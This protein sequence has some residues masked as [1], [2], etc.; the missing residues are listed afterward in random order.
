MLGN[1]SG[2]VLYAGR[3]AAFCVILA[4]ALAALCV[5]L[6]VLGP[7]LAAAD[8]AQTEGPPD[9]A[10]P[11]EAWVK[12]AITDTP[13]PVVAGEELTYA[14]SATN[15]GPAVASNLRMWVE[16]PG[17]SDFVSSSFS[18]GSGEGSCK[19]VDAQSFGTTCLVESLA[20]GESAVFEVVVRPRHPGREHLVFDAWAENGPGLTFETSE[21]TTVL[22]PRGCTIYGTERGDSFGGDIHGT[23][24]PDV[25]CALGGSDRVYGGGGDDTILAGEGDD[26]VYGGEGDDT[27]RGGR[28][29]EFD[30]VGGAGGDDIFGG[31]GSDDLRARDGVRGNDEARG[32]SGY[33]IV[34]A[35][36]GDFARD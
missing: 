19:P 35:D 22:D 26:T 7:G 4:M 17:D 29:N 10:L 36:P 27:I 12:K 28:G 5:P 18:P 30:L 1:G 25:I 8:P 33:D 14:A 3:A 16:L 15:L 9:M 34:V 31:R 2:K 32:G 20:V 13:D 23:S 6:L 24:G 21:D 11:E